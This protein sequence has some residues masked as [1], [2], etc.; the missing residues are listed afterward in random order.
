MSDRD[1]LLKILQSHVSQLA[2]Y[3]DSVQIFC[4][5]KKEEETLS[6]FDGSGNWFSRYGQITAWI[7]T[8]E[9]DFDSSRRNLEDDNDE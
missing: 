8:E 2:E 4:T 9:K 6:F 7:K 3:F 1:R 5:V